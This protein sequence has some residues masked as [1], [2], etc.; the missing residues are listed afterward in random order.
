LF[1]HLKTKYHD[2]KNFLCN[3]IFTGRGNGFSGSP[4][5]LTL[6]AAF[7]NPVKSLKKANEV[8]AYLS[9]SNNVIN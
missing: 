4:L 9:K 3:Y 5:F 8:M 1:L 6:K 2:N 7:A